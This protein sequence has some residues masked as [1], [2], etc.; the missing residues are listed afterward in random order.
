MDLTK[1]PLSLNSVISGEQIANELKVLLGEKI[2]LTFKAR[3]DGS[4]LRKMIT[5]ILSK[6]VSIVADEKSYKILPLKGKGIPRLLAVLADTYIVTSGKSYNLQ[7]WNRIPNSSSPLVIYTNGDFITAKDIRL[8]LVKIDMNNFTIDSIITMSPQYIKEHFGEFGKPTIKSQLLISAI[9][10][11]KIIKNGGVFFN[12]D[13]IRMSKHT[14]KQ[15]IKP[16]YKSDDPPTNDMLLSLDVIKEIVAEKLIGKKLED[17]DT[18]TKG[19]TLERIVIDLLGYSSNSKLV[20]GYPDIPNQLLEVKVQDTQT[21]DL[22]K[23]SPQ[24]EEPTDYSNFTTFDVR[25]LIAFTNPKS[26][27]IEG[28]I[29]SN[30]EALGQ[31]FTYVSDKSYKCQ[32]SIPM[33]FFEKYS[34]KSLFNP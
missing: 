29:L 14:N 21:V 18:K 10:R 23:Y 19:Q 20:G 13:S 4:N 6:N 3:T 34:G 7:V 12:S 30:G 33:D 28:L 31:T 9:E 17:S 32:R 27:I 26:H 5:N 8:I 25:Y 11:D 2:I 1:A 22:G 24:Y 16:H 15:Y